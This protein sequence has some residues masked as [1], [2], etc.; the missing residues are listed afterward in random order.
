MTTRVTEL[1]VPYLCAG[2]LGALDEAYL[3][4]DDPIG[5]VRTLPSGW[6]ARW[7]VH[8]VEPADGHVPR[9]MTVS[10]AHAV[11]LGVGWP[12][13]RHRAY[14]ATA[15]PRGSTAPKDQRRLLRDEESESF[16]RRADEARRLATG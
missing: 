16:E 6:V 4:N 10:G 11:H 15:V 9:A 5:G 3:T 13:E 7:P 2:C 14:P 8:R 1:P 12:G